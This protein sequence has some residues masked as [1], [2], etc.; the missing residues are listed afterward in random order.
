MTDYNF[1]IHIWIKA[2][3]G[4]TLL[5]DDSGIALNIYKK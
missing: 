5:S 1:E 4:Q 3:N 2:K